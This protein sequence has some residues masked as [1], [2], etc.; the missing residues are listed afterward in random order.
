MKSGTRSGL[1]ALADYPIR[2][3]WRMQAFLC[4]IFMFQYITQLI[5][6]CYYLMINV[7]KNYTTTQLDQLF[8][9][10]A[11]Q[12]IPVPPPPPRP[13]VTPGTIFET[14]FSTA[15]YN[16]TPVIEPNMEKRPSMSSTWMRPLKIALR[17]HPLFTAADTLPINVA[18]EWENRPRE[19]SAQPVNHQ[20][21]S[22]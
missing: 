18:L 22:R 10:R 12:H 13:L 17:D 9:A 6:Y 14:L 5:C 8:D 21:P 3:R 15:P 16:S 11:N 7:L 19:S 2:R 20:Q 1:A 4:Y